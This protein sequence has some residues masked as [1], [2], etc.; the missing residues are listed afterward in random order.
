MIRRVERY[1]ELKRFASHPLHVVAAL[2]V[3]FRTRQRAPS[4]DVTLDTGEV[5]EGAEFAIVS[6]MAPY[7]YLGR[8]PIQVAPA[9]LDD[10][11]YLTVM[12]R[13]DAVTLLGAAACRRRRSGQFLRRREGIVHRHELRQLTITSSHPIPHQV[14]GDDL[15][16]ADRLDV[17]YEPEVLT[18]V[19]P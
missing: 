18:L 1:G 16:D 15:G 3:W 12:R 19:V 14:D 2:D 11:L 8:H 4:F 13:L 6:K 9:G 17:T 10:P 5:V 7:T